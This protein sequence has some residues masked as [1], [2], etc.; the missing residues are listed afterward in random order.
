MD[1]L[2]LSPIGDKINFQPRLPSL[3]IVQHSGGWLEV[4]HAS[5]TPSPAGLHQCAVLW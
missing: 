4:L 1:R 2:I 3:R 5:S